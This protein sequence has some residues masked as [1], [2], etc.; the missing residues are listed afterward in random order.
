MTFFRSGKCVINAA[1]SAVFLSVPAVCLAEE[2]PENS[3]AWSENAGWVN[4]NSTHQ[5]ISAS[6]DGLSGYAWAENVGWIRFGADGG[7]PYAN[8]GT[9]NWGVNRDESNALQGYAWGETIGWIN[10][11]PTHGGVTIDPVNQSLG[12]FAWAENLGWISF[13]NF[14]VIFSSSFESP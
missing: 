11:D 7:P 6:A 13:S 2:L 5:A 14:V 3:W 4:L 12:G 1:I 8:T 9:D 10:F